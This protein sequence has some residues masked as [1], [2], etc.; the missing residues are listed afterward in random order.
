MLIPALAS[1]HKAHRKV[2]MLF[3]IGTEFEGFKAAAKW[4]DAKIGVKHFTHFEKIAIVSDNDLIMKS[5]KIFGS[6]MPGELELFR[7]DQMENAKTWI[8]A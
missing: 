3:L 4:D 6:M 5:K 1:A 2:R 8:L 7:N